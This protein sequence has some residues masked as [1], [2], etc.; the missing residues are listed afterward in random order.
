MGRALPRERR[1]SDVT[2]A[3][4]ASL[5][6]AIGGPTALVGAAKWWLERS[7]RLRRED[8]AREDARVEAS[9]R[10]YEAMGAA[11]TSTAETLRVLGA[12]IAR[13]PAALTPLADDIAEL[14]RAVAVLDARTSPLT[15]EHRAGGV[16]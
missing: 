3:E 12:E 5:V 15:G 4:I 16:S 2:T 8:L 13:V 14:R 11:M 9:A 10:R 7:E 1:G 6:G